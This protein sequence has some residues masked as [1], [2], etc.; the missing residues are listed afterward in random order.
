MEP[1]LLRSAPLFAG[2]G[3]APIDAAAALCEES[4]HPPNTVIA[5]QGAP[6]DALHL[7]ERGSARLVRV[8]P[9][10]D[11]KTV[12]IARAGELLAPLEVL[13]GEAFPWTARTLE[14]TRVVSIRR[15]ALHDLVLGYPE[16]G[17]HL[18][19]WLARAN[20]RALARLDEG[21]PYGDGRRVAQ[22]LL[23]LARHAGARTANGWHLDFSVDHD[24]LATLA[25]TTRE[26]VRR[27]LR[28][29]CRAGAI[30]LARRGLT[31]VDEE[32]LREWM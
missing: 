23:D 28:E 27:V 2:L 26:A 22:L 5:E 7:I 29:L 14:F 3:P 31:I 21:A 18:I 24:E 16:L 10:E 30:T 25:C 13:A 4:E 20:L 9:E 17:L 1:A 8:A 19:G 15:A 32:R 6:A 11:R 12:G